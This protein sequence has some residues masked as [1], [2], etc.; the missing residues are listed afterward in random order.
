MAK[1]GVYAGSFDPVTNGHVDIIQRALGIVDRLIVAVG[2]SAEKTG[3]FPVDERLSMLKSVT[4]GLNNVEFTS[5]SGLTVEFAASA[6]AQIL[7]RGLRSSV[8]FHYELT[9]A[10]MNRNLEGSLETIFLVANPKYFH[11]SSSLV[12]EVA[13]YGGNLSHAVDPI[14]LSKLSDTLAK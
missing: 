7:I 3:L 1:L 5:F 10:E 4:K 6:G 13:R 14:V 9:M 8:D 2:V 12:K 11:L